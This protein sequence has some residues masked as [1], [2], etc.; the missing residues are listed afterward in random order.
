MLRT[1]RSIDYRAAPYG[2]IATIPKGT[3]VTPATNLLYSGKYWAE[4]W[5]NMTPR[6]EGW[7][8][9][10]GFLIDEKDVDVIIDEP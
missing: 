2:L 8:Y 5:D 7:I 9:C 6:A 4:P 10:Y 3:P 1:N